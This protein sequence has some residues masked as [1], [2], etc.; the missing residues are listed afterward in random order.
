[1]QLYRRNYSWNVGLIEDEPHV[2]I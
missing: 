2:V 1:M